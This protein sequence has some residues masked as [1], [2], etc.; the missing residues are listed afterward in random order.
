MSFFCA[1]YCNDF[2][3][4]ATIVCHQFVTILWQFYTILNKEN[5]EMK[6]LMIFGA[7]IA[8]VALSPPSRCIC[9]WRKV[10]CQSYTLY[11][12]STS[13]DRRPADVQF[14]QVH[15]GL[16]FVYS[17]IWFHSLDTTWS[18]FSRN[19]FPAYRF[20]TILVVHESSAWNVL[21]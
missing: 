5:N 11:S 16:Q 14:P 7:L 6:R 20:G 21:L 2:A 12:R 18:C 19:V 3:I 9:G 13:C 8:T 17:F 4:C 15:H 10:D 1:T